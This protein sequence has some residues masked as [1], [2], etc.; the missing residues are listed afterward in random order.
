MKSKPME[1]ILKKNS[2]GGGSSDPFSATKKGKA[3]VSI[4]TAPLGLGVVKLRIKT[5]TSK[6][7]N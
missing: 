5:T 7:C 1:L 4:A 2:Q 3:P 6:L